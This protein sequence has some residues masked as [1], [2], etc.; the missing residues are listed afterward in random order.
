[1]LMSYL[2]GALIIFCDRLIVGH[3]FNVKLLRTNILMNLWDNF[4][5]MNFMNDLLYNSKKHLGT[6][7]FNVITQI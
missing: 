2:N 3:D 5:F 1:M 4:L 6:R 7:S